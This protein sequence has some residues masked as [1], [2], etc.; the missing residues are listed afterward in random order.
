MR[1]PLAVAALL[2]LS[3]CSSPESSDSDGDSETTMSDTP[4]MKMVSML[5]NSFRN[6]DFSTAPGGKAMYMNQGKNAHT[7]TIHMV[8]DSETTS[9]IDK[10]L[11]PGET[12]TYTFATV[13]TYHVYCKLHGT[14]T[15][16]MTSTVTVA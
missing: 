3:G 15:T 11:Q 4:S 6:G 10:T 2:L 8:G 14:M 1:L 9:K 12:E 13:G 5:D 7:V 16:G